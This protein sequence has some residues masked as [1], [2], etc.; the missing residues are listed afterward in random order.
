MKKNGKIWREK[1]REII[2]K[3]KKSNKKKKKKS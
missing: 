3:K 2:S 1:N